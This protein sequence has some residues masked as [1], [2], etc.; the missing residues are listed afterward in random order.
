MSVPQNLKEIVE[1]TVST[2]PY[3]G[4]GKELWR[5]SRSFPSSASRSV[6]SNKTGVVFFLF[7]PRLAVSVMITGPHAV[8]LSC[9]VFTGWHACAPPHRV[10]LVVSSCASI[11][12]F[13]VSHGQHSTLSHAWEVTKSFRRKPYVF[14]FPHKVHVLFSSASTVAT[15]I[16]NMFGLSGAPCGIPLEVLNCPSLIARV[17]CSHRFEIQATIF[18]HCFFMLRFSPR[19]RPLSSNPFVLRRVG[20]PSLSLSRSLSFFL[21]FTLPF[22]LSLD[23]FHH[24]SISVSIRAPHTVLYFNFRLTS[25]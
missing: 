1:M 15:R 24:L 22:A 16:V 20:C 14:I 9:Q 11:L 19:G 18:R 8:N 13:N 12:R 3:T 10:W 17:C 4:L 23:R 25:A 2:S 5:L 21:F 7:S 6:S